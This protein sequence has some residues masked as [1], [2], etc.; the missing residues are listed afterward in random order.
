MKIIFSSILAL[1]VFCACANY[2]EISDQREDIVDYLD[3]LGVEYTTFGN[4]FRY[5]VEDTTATLGSYIN[6]GSEF[7]VYFAA[8]TFDGG[9]S[10]LYYT[11]V[12]SLAEA[13]LSGLNTQYW[14]FD[15]LEI[16]LGTSEL[17]EGLTTALEGCQYGQTVNIIMCYDDAYGDKSAGIVA[18]YSA[19][20]YTIQIL[21]Q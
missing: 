16:T 11:N 14:S 13:S 19:I 7:S 1:F 21:E 18:D 6:K 2:N 3:G 17:L 12:E 5:I 20:M 15:P 10:E 9:P 8:Y 4:T